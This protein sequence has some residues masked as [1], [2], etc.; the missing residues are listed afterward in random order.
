MIALNEGFRGSVL[1]LNKKLL[2][3]F[4]YEFFLTFPDKRK[5]GILKDEV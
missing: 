1:G 3:I 5:I 2:Y 4:Y